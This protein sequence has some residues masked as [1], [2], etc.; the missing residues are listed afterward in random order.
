LKNTNQRREVFLFVKSEA[1]K[2]RES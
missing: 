1:E 2:V